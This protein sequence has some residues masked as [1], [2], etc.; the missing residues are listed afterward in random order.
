MPAEIRAATLDDL[1]QMVD[2]L[3]QDA[4][5]RQAHDPVLWV[6]DDDALQRWERPSNSP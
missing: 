2:L 4:R 5:S 6:L 1:P 3:M